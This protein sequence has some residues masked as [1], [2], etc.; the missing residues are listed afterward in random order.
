MEVRVTWRNVLQSIPP[1]VSLALY[2]IAQEALTNVSKHAGRASVK[3]ALTGSGRGLDLRV[4]DNGSGFD[5]KN[6][7]AGGGLGRSAWRS[8][9]DCLTAHCCTP[10]RAKEPK[11][12]FTCRSRRG[13]RR[14]REGTERTSR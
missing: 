9:P 7:K 2:R 5:M 12:M 3:I 13:R 8:V 11:F 6:V 4:R 14:R 10:N 1:P